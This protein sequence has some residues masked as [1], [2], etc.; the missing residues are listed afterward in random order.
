MFLLLAVT[1]IAGAANAQQRQ[2][3][4]QER[5]S[6]IAGMGFMT[7]PTNFLFGLEVLVPLTEHISVGP[8]FQ[9]G[10]E[11]NVK[12][13]ALSL[14]ARYQ[15]FGA[16]VG[17]FDIHPFGEVGM[18]FA[19]TSVDT[20][21]F[22]RDVDDNAF[23]LDLATGAEIP[24]NEHVSVGTRMDFLIHPNLFRDDFTWSWQIITARYRF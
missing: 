19:R 7:D 1:L 11:D 5:A 21:R 20:G 8:N 4:V 24:I 13:Y 14:N 22:F 15:A 2:R 17:D 18:G 10:T 16:R 6:V 9:L 12:Y 3:Q 23:L